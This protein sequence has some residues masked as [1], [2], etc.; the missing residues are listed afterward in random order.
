MSVLDGIAK[1]HASHDC[2]PAKCA[3]RC[4]CNQQLG[5]TFLSEFCGACY[6]AWIRDE[7]D[8]VVHGPSGVGE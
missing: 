2:K 4:G 1:Y 3:C 6:L 8:L 5:C 7:D